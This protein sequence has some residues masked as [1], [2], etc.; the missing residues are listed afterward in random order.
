MEFIIISHTNYFYGLW[1]VIHTICCLFSSYFYAFMAAFGQP[2][3]DTPLYK[4]DWFFEIVF[5]ISFLLC[6]LVDFVPEGG[7]RPVRNFRSIAIRYLKGGFIMDFLP[8]IPFVQMIDLGGREKHFYIIRILR[9]VAGFKILNVRKIMDR[10]TAIIR[11]RMMKKD[12]LKQRNF[13]ELSE[14]DENKI[15]LVVLINFTLRILKLVIIILNISY[16]VGFFFFIFQDI[17]GEYLDDNL[18]FGDNF[19]EEH[20]SIYISIAMMYFSITSLS[21]VGFGDFAP[22]SKAERVLFCF[23]LVFGVAIFSYMMGIFIDIL[24]KYQ[25]LNADLDEGDDLSKFFGLLKQLNNNKPID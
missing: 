7:S 19:S 24:G 13:V 1:S 11:D 16:F 23:V 22:L 6:F 2:E 17:C 15:S 10:I 20:G 3:P 14:E 25:D 5:Y 8:I 18:K 21:T 9:L 12:A 4:L